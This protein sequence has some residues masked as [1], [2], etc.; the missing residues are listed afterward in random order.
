MRSTIS[1]PEAARQSFELITS[2][3]SDGPSQLVLADNFTG[4][5]TLLDDFITSTGL[6]VES[7]HRQGRR[8]EPLTAAK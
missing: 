1:H 2:L 6:A 4:L 3:A 7:Q 8:K 5:V